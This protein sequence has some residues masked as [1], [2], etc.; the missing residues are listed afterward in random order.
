MFYKTETWKLLMLVAKIVDEL[1]VAGSGNNA[2]SFMDTFN[3]KFKIGTI[4][5]GPGN[6]RF[7]DF[8]IIQNEIMSMEMDENDKI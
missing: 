1:K 3:C 8:N 2:Q 4:K 6:F 5:S 7:F